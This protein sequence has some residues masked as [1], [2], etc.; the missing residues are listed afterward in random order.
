MKQL[1]DWFICKV[2][3]YINFTGNYI[4]TAVYKHLL[5]RGIYIAVI[6]VITIELSITFGKIEAKQHINYCLWW[7]GC[8]GQP[9]EDILDNTH[10]Y[11]LLP[12]ISLFIVNNQLSSL[13]ILLKGRI[14]VMMNIVRKPTSFFFFLGKQLS[15]EMLPHIQFPKSLWLS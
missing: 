9:M 1:F 7:A 5:L 12:M 15:K 8:P 6:I 11:Y 2:S 4:I 14:S 13:L 3:L 10:I